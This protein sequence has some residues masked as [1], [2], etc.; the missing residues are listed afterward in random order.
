MNRIKKWHWKLN[1][2]HLSSSDL[3]E[4][5]AVDVRICHHDGANIT[6]GHNMIIQ[7]LYVNG[8]YRVSVFSFDRA[9]H[10]SHDYQL[11]LVD[12]LIVCIR[13]TF[14]R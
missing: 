1:T 2:H 10:I 4:L 9:N 6:H 5:I 3:N 12:V 14:N 11:N 7:L 8:G 13:C